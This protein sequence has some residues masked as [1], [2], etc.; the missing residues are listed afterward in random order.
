MKINDIIGTYTILLFLQGDPMSTNILF[1]GYSY[2]SQR[3]YTQHKNGVPA[4][5]FR[6]QTEGRCE[7]TANGKKID[8]RPGSLLLLKP[9]DTYELQIEESENG[10]KG[11]F[12]SSGDYHLMCE[13]CWIDEWWNRS[14]KSLASRIDPDERLLALWRQLMV[15]KRRSSSENNE[16]LTDY[17]LRALCLHLERAVKETSPAFSQPNAVIRMQRFIEEHATST[18]KVE[19]AAQQAGLSVSRAVHLFK[20]SFGKTMLEYAHEIRLSAALEQMRY[21]AMTLDQIAESCGFGAYPYFHRVF[22]RNYGV[23]PG[24]YRREMN[25]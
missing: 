2:H 22:K 5:L 20:D 6:L 12:V 21:T 24:E 18:F 16:E 7:V 8:T 1:C 10:V 17:L 23:A 25:V 3:F 4:Y 15:E 14:S 11:P 19:D 9:G 13:G